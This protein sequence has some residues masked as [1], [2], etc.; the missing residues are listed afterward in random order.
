MTEHGSAGWVSDAV[1]DMLA[2]EAERVRRALHVGIAS[3]N[4]WEREAGV[5]RTLVN[6]DVAGTGAEARPAEEIYPVHSFPALVTLLER[7]TPYC[8]GHGDPVDVASASLV[9]SLGL[10]TQAAAPIAVGGEVWGSLWVATAPGE[11]P[12]SAEDLPSVARAANAIARA[13]GGAAAG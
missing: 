13:L 7:R 1:L 4:V 12:L 10:D 3:I 5:L 11:R 2:V 6:A 9:A 8:F